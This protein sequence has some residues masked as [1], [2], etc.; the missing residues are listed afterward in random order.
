ME[1]KQTIFLFLIAT[2]SQYIFSSDDSSRSSSS[3]PIFRNLRESSDESF[4]A[5]TTHHTFVTHSQLLDELRDSR[6][7]IRRIHESRAALDLRSRRQTK[8]IQNQG[9]EITLLRYIINRQRKQ[10]AALKKSLVDFNQRL[11][12]LEESS[13]GRVY[14]Q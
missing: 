7:H 4:N 9:K 8:Q 2:F 1:A 5:T 12:E 14:R 10:I 6:S 13:S 11:K 3:N